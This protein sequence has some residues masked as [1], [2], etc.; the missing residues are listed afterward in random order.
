MAETIFTANLMRTLLA[1]RLQNQMSSG[2]MALFFELRNGTGFRPNERYIDAFAMHLWPSKGLARYAY[3]IKVSRS[4]FLHE[5][6]NPNKRAWGMEISNEFWFVCAPGIAKP[7]EIPEGCGLL[8]ASKNGKQLRAAVQPMHRQVRDLDMA[9]VAAIAR[10]SCQKDHYSDLRWRYAGQEI[11]KAQLDE[12]IDKERDHSDER[13]IEKKAK[14]L[15]GVELSRIKEGLSNYAKALEDAGCEAPAWMKFDGSDRRLG[16]R[17][18]SSW[19]ADEWVK[20]H[21]KP[22]PALSLVESALYAASQCND[23]LNH[24]VNSVEKLKQLEDNAPNEKV[25]TFG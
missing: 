23:H 14:E 16:A 19:S 25:A 8:V 6:K 7:E 15:A 2:S 21:I 11:D 17:S 13:K 12:I 3:E 24:L 1:Q 18:M 20:Q 5:L 4:D 9:E 10:Q 22:G